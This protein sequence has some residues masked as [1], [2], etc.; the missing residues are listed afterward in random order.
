ML[1][2][3]FEDA[4]VAHDTILA[5]GYCSKHSDQKKREKMRARGRK[6]DYS[7]RNAHRRVKRCQSVFHQ[8]PM[9][10]ISLGMY[11]SGEDARIDATR[12]DGTRRYTDFRYPLCLRTRSGMPFVLSSGILSEYFSFCLGKQEFMVLTM[13]RRAA[14]HGVRDCVFTCMRCLKS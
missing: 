4:L 10:R 8:S 12:H 5:L 3:F 7:R 11:T 6:Y 13:L 14:R 9:E 1:F 2:N